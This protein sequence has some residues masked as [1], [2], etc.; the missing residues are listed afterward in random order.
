MEARVRAVRDLR[1]SKK[2]WREAVVAL[3]F[4]ALILLSD[5]DNANG[6]HKE[7][8]LL[9]SCYISGTNNGNTYNRRSG[10]TTTG[11]LVA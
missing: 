5:N 2:A 10:H 1:E 8:E 4:R 9:D 3:R 11:G 7:T 6:A